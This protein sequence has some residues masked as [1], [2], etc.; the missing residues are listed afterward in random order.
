[1]NTT[2]RK[3][4]HGDAGYIAERMNPRVI[5]CKV[6]IYRA[7]EQGIDVNGKK[8]AVVCDAHGT[9]CGTTNLPDARELMKHPGNF[10]EKCAW[11]L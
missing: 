10:C 5:S 8:Y 1:M 2:N 3:Q 6:V 4:H 9:M 11:L 7:V